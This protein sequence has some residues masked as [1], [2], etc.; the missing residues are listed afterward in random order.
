M[1]RFDMNKHREDLPEIE[2]DELIA[3]Y[4]K[5]YGGT[6][7]DVLDGLGYTNRFYTGARRK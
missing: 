2:E 5:L 7:S 3:R 4:L 1:E 6:I